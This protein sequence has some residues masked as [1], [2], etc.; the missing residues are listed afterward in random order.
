MSTTSTLAVS[1]NSPVATVQNAW[2]AALTEWKAARGLMDGFYAIGS[3]YRANDDW[4]RSGYDLET[5]FGSIDA[6]KR[7]PTGKRK[8]DKRFAAYAKVEETQSDYYEPAD[9][10]ARRLI[11]TPAPN[12]DAVLLKIEVT[13]TH[14]LH[15]AED[16]GDEPWQIIASELRA[17]RGEA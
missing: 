9:E 12:V 1:S 3:M 13:K 14:E 7:H 17:M 15:F 4:T 11:R 10:A 16:M 6:A 8:V 5:E 2:D